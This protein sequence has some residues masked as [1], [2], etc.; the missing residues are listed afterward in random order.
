L[1]DLDLEHLGDVWRQQPDPAELERLRRTAETVRRRARWSQAVDAVAAL[2]VAGV[3]LL[4]VAGN[5]ELDTMI[6]GGGAVLV[7]LA[8]HIRSRR[9][10]EEELRSLSGSAEQMLDQSVARLKAKIKRTRYQLL[11]L[12]P[13]FGIGIAIAY[14]ADEGAGQQ[15]LSRLI[16][17][18]REAGLLFVGGLVAVAAMFLYLLRNL[19]AERKELDRLAA[20]R[21]SYD[22]EQGPVSG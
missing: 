15:A 18:S 8:G 7:L 9:L 1:T 3:V 6:V 17:N 5:P 10:R 16:T 11:C 12:L 4:L 19:R 14:F 20:L 21:Q 13:G 22:D 2:L